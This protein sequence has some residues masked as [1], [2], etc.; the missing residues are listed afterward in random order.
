MC[1][2]KLQEVAVKPANEY[3][4]VCDLS[5][6]AFASFELHLALQIDVT[7]GKQTKLNVL[8]HCPYGQT[9]L[10]MANEDLVGRLPLRKE[11]GY[12]AVDLMKTLD[13]KVN[14]GAG[15]CKKLSILPIR[16]Q[17]IIAILVRHCTPRMAFVAAVTNIRSPC[18]PAAVFLV[19]ILTMLITAGTGCAFDIAEDDLI[20]YVGA[21]TVKAFCAEVVGIK[22]EAFAGMVF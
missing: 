17:G 21:V 4:P 8:I 3:F 10:G 11:R 22:E 6:M 15:V 18:E 2:R 7:S 13:G 12:D 14:T 9:E 16:K 5:L 1:G 20:T 19:E